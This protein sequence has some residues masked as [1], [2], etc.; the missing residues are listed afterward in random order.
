MY[1]KSEYRGRVILTRVTLNKKQRRHS[2]WVY[3]DSTIRAKH[4][5]II[6]ECLEPQ[7]FWDDWQDTRDGMRNWHGD[8][9]KIKR[10]LH[11]SLNFCEECDKLKINN[12]KLKKLIRRRKVR[13]KYELEKRTRWV[14]NIGRTLKGFAPEFI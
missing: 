4:K 13:K 1:I 14:F 6:D 12:K 11:T 8:R 5:E 3:P 2:G 10:K 7:S 9:S